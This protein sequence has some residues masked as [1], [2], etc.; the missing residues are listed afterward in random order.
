MA[1]TAA[2]TGTGAAAGLL[3][4]THRSSSC[5]AAIAYGLPDVA[6]HVIDTHVEPSIIE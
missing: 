5:S 3:P 1:S 2:V 6:R 4:P